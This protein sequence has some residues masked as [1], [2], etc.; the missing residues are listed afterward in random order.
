MVLLPVHHPKCCG[1]SC[2]I[3]ADER[4]QLARTERRQEVP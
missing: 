4:H 3:S 1:I 2:L